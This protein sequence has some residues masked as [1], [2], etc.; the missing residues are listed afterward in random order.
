MTAPGY[1]KFHHTPRWWAGCSTLHCEKLYL[2]TGTTGIQQRALTPTTRSPR[3][4]SRPESLQ[5][6]AML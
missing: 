6:L 4:P 1:K 5:V 3:S 2:K